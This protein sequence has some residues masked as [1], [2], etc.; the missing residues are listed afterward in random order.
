ML[1]KIGLLLLDENVELFISFFS[2]EISGFS[3]LEALLF[4]RDD[5]LKKLVLD[6]LDLNL[7]VSDL[8]FGGGGLSAEMVSLN[9]L[10]LNL[11]LDKVNSLLGLLGNTR[12]LTLLELRLIDL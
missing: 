4:F 3:S 12:C 5:L 11:V 7:N 8:L 10:S 6:I 9:F 2:D 1:S